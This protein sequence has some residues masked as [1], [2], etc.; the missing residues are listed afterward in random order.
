MARQTPLTE[1]VLKSHGR[2]LRAV[3][4][5]L[6]GRGY[7]A[8]GIAAMLSCDPGVIYR[9]ARRYNITLPSRMRTPPPQNRP[10]DVEDDDGPRLVQVERRRTPIPDMGPFNLLRR[11]WHEAA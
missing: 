1:R 5:E 9:Y 8:Y 2:P 11:P 6:T 3:L 10:H 4:E 7:S